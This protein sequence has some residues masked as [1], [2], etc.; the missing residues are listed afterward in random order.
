MEFKE[1]E[2]QSE[3]REVNVSKSNFIINWKILNNKIMEIQNEIK[4]LNITF[5]PVLKFALGDKEELVKKQSIYRSVYDHFIDELL[6]ELDNIKEQIKE[7]NM[8]GVL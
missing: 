2:I 1:A 7:I 4:L 6:N 3:M 5:T 8:R